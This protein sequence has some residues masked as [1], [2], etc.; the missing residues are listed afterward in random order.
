M[1]FDAN[2]S[3]ALPWSFEPVLREITLNI[4]Q[5]ELA[6]YRVTNKSDKPVTGT[7]TFNVTPQLA[8]GYFNKI[9][10]FCFEEQRLAP[11]ESVE[12]PVSFFIDP[13]ILND[14]DAKGITEI[15]LSY[16]FSP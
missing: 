15:T 2:T 6:F 5:N 1:R 12:M 13:A 8:G 10:C 3:P 7:A 9:Q 16:T 14:E 4:G 11:G